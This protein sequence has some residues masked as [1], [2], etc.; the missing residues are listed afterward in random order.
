MNVRIMVRYGELS[1]KGKNK[2]SFTQRLAQNVR[3]VLQDFEQIKVNPDYD[4]MYIT[5]NGAPEE[6]VLERLKHVFGIQSYSPIYTVEK[7][8]EAMFQQIYALLSNMDLSD[9]TFKISTKRADHEFDMDTNTLNRE[10]GA[11]VLDAFPQLTV[12]VKQ[13][14]INIKVEVRKHA[15]YISTQTY[16]GAGGLP[17]GTGGRGMM[18]LSGGIDSP[19]ASYLALKRGLEL[20]MVHFYSPPYTSPQSL[21]KTQELTKKLALYGGAIQF[22]EV[23]FTEIQETIK[24]K[25]P[26]AYLMTITRRFMLRVA[27]AIRQKRDGLVILNGESM[28]QVAS[29]TL[30]SMVAINEVTNTPILR[31]VV[32]MDKLDIIALAEK[33]DTF[34]LSIQPFEDCCTVFAPPSPKTKPNLEKVRVYEERLDVDALVKR[35]VDG[36]KVY[37]ID[38]QT[39]FDEDVEDLL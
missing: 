6:V 34:E 35:A 12:K 4:F 15:V 37:P 11:M 22:I 7:S 16:I 13:P 32:A 19:V 23:P 2:K 5:L 31:P 28:G 33:I 17:V 3:H 29:Q 27:D 24:E 21:R 9:K 10:L 8:L 38:V 26:E 18:M 14:D 39:R 25:C 36:I 1:T 30:H 20:E